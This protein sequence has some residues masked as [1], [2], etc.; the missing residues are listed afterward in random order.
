MPH[1]IVL[2]RYHSKGLKAVHADPQVLIGMHEALERW[3]AKVL[4]SYSTLGIWDHCLIIDAPNNFT[5]YRAVLEQ[6]MSVT[7][8][9]EILPAIDLPLFQRLIS[10]SA[11]T[12][13]PQKW[14]I[15]WWARLVRLLMYD[16]Q[17][18]K[19]AREYF[20][21]HIVTGT[22]KFDDVRGTCI[23]VSNHA[24]H[25]DQ[26]CL[27]KAIPWRIRT[28]LFFGAAADRWFLKGRKDIRLQPWFVS[29]VGGVYP[30]HRGG[31][32]KTLDYPKW[33]LDKGAN[34]MLF[35]EGTRSR[36]RH[37]SK[38][39]YGVAILALEKQVPVVPVYMTG[40]KKIRPPGT[41]EVVPGPVAAHV[42]DPIYFDAST[43]VPE[44]TQRI[45]EAMK[46][47]HER[48]L[49]H[50]DAAAHSDWRP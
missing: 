5:A 4:A 48:V 33:L 36:G 26:L 41:R 45:F 15:Q 2:M 16:Y 14:Q 19:G 20:T 18:G 11:E 38:F 13:G 1:Y 40:L 43:T 42:L 50:G 25:F 29:L 30:I 37:L 21:E 6:E 47:V 32:S 12:V 8:E 3:E 24:S 9:T 49:E 23:V 44:A 35:P 17:Y 7:G 22:E 28:N 10:Q 46:T 34:L 39:K 31:G 27:M